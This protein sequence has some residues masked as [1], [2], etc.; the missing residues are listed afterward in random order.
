MRDHDTEML[1]QSD[2]L[3]AALS[4]SSMERHVHSFTLFIHLFYK[5]PI[6]DLPLASLE[7]SLAKSRAW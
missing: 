7:N 2:Q 4:N 6:V 5:W 1:L 3:C